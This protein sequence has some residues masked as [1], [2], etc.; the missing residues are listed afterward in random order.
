VSKTVEEFLVKKI[1]PNLLSVSEGLQ[2][3]LEKNA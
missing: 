1:T 3:Y 2:R